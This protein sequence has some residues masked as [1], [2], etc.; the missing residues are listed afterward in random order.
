MYGQNS[1]YITSTDNAKIY[2][3]EK[4]KGEPV[5]L[6]AGGPGLNPDYLIP[7][8]EELSQHYRV[9]ILHQRGTGKSIVSNVDA[10]SMSMENYKN[11]LE[12][13]RKHLKLDKLTLIGHSWGAMLA[14]EYASSFP[15]KVKNLIL[16]SSGGPTRSFFSYFGDNIEMRLTKKD[17]EEKAKLDSL[18]Q[19]DLKAIWPGY[20]FDRKTALF[21]KSS[22][23]FDSLYG[24]KNVDRYTMNNYISKDSARVNDLKRYLGKASII[25]GWQDPIGAAT[26]Y[27]IKA[28]LPQ[29]EIHFIRQCGH[30]PWLENEEQKI[31]FYELLN[32][33]ILDE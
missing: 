2:I 19:S 27:E 24:Q 33:A 32:A 30:F 21:Y 18:K 3:Q 15:E 16:V 26:V 28:V 12:S 10:S 4:G 1:Y 20:F 13:L 11:D 23:D 31:E 22:I 5:I 6:L 29:I 7:I 8:L 17:R 25:Q 9:I 14:M